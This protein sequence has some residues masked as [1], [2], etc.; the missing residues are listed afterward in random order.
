MP[1][2]YS[3][4]CRASM[5]GTPI[6]RAMVLDHQN[7]SLAWIFDKQ[8]MWGKEMLV[9]PNCSGAYADVK[10]W[11]PKGKWFDYW[12]DSVYNGD[13]VISYPSP[14]GR[15]PLFVKAGAIIPMEPY[16]LST[17]FIPND[18]LTIHVYKGADGSFELIEYDGQTEAYT[19]GE[20]RFTRMHFDDQ[21][22]SF[23]CEAANGSIRALLK[24]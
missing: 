17:A 8:Y 18:S 15:L 4:A 19:K 12:N 11:L 7:D 14:V 13:Q 10:V 6:A 21:K 16:A 22:F 24:K 9:A 2:N 3:Y 5:N 1:Y 23:R 20:S